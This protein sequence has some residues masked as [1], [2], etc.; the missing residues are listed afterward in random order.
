MGKPGDLVCFI[1]VD[2]DVLEAFDSDENA[3]NEALRA[4][5]PPTRR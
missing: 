4:I 5:A 1:Q 3:I 2:A